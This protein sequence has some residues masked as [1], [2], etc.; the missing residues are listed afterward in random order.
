[1]NTLRRFSRR[2]W[3]LHGYLIVSMILGP[4]PPVNSYW[5]DSDQDGVKEWVNDPAVGGAWWDLD[6]DG[7]FLT[8]AEE[9]QFGS[10]PYSKDSD[11]DGLSD[12]VERDYTPPA[13]P[14]DPWKWD[15]DDNGCSD[16]DEYYHLIQGYIPVVNYLNLP[17]GAAWA[18]GTFFSFSD[19]DGDGTTNPNDSDPLNMDNDSDGILNWEDSWPDDAANGG[20]AWTEP[21][22]MTDSD[23][24]G[25]DDSSDP[26]PYGSYWHLGIEYGGTPS[27]RDSDGIP[28]EV[29]SFPDGS[30]WYNGFEY[31]GAGS[32]QD[33]DGI[34]DDFDS[35]PSIAGSYSYGG[36]EYPGTWNDQDGDGIPDPADGTSEG[37]YWYNG[38]EYI[39]A[40]V[41]QDEDGIPD[42]FDPFPATAGSYTYDGVEYPGVWVDSDSDGT[43]DALD[44]TPNGGYLYNGV[45][46]TGTWI[47]TDSD[48]V[49]DPADSMP[50]G[51]Y[52]WNNVEYEGLWYDQ[53]NDGIPDA[54]D[55][56]PAGGYWYGDTEYA[57][58]WIDSDGDTIP[59]PADL[60]PNGS[61]WY[62]G[63]EYAGTWNDADSDNI[64]DAAD[65]W[66]NDSW[67][68]QPHFSY[69]GS[70]YAGEWSDRDEDSVPDAADSWPDDPENGADDD[71]DGLSNY[72]ERTQHFT[73][74]NDVDSDDDYLTDYEELMVFH[75]NPLAPRTN[76][77]SGQTLLDGQL[78]L[79]QLLM[80]GDTDG[81]GLPDVL[82]DFY[83][84]LGYD[85]KKDRLDPLDPS[86]PYQD[87]G[88]GDLD[89]DGISNREAFQR[90][91]S[92]IANLNV[93]DFD[94][95]RID[96]AVEDYWAAVYPGSLDKT[97]FADAV[98]DFDQDGLMNYEEVI[99][100][101]IGDQLV[102]LNPGDS[103]SIVNALG[104]SAAAGP[105]TTDGQIMA[106]WWDVS[107][108][109][110]G[111]FDDEM[112]PPVAIAA[113][114]ELKDGADQ[115]L[116]NGMPD[117]YE[118]WL[119]EVGSNPPRAVAAD[120]DGDGI[121]NLWEY[122]YQFDLRDASDAG[123]AQGLALVSVPPAGRQP[124]PSDPEF[125]FESGS[126]P[127]FNTEAYEAAMAAYYAQQGLHLDALQ[128]LARI[129]PD[130]DQLSNR[131]EFILG[132]HPR[133][134][135][136]D[137]DG[138]SDLIETQYGTD[139]LVT[140]SV[141]PLVLSVVSGGDGT[142]VV[143]GQPSPDPLVVRITQGGLAT[144]GVPVT[145]SSSTGSLGF[146]FTNSV[147]LTSGPDG[148]S[149][150]PIAAANAA[151]GVSNLEVSAVGVVGTTSV[152]FQILAAPGGGV[153]GGGGPVGGGPVSTEPPPPEYHVFSAVR[154]KSVS[155]RG[156]ETPTW[157]RTPEVTSST[158]S[159]F[160]HGEPG[161]IPP[162]GDDGFNGDAD[163]EN[164]TTDPGDP[165]D[166]AKAGPLPPEPPLI[167]AAEGDEGAFPITETVHVSGGEPSGPH[168]GKASKTGS[169]TAKNAY[170]P[171]DKED[172]PGT[173]F[174]EGTATTTMDSVPFHQGSSD[175]GWMGNGPLGLAPYQAHS[176]WTQGTGTHYLPYTDSNGDAKVSELE[177]DFEQ[178]FMSHMEVRLQTNK[179]VDPA[180][181]PPLNAIY[182]ILKETSNVADFS[183]TPP[184]VEP[185]ATV[186]FSISTGKL[187]D[188]VNV[189]SGTLPAGI[190]TTSGTLS[191][192]S[193]APQ[194]GKI[195]RYSVKPVG[196]LRD[197]DTLNDNWEPLSGQLARALPGELI[198]L[199][200]N[201]GDLPTDVTLGGFSW[202]LPEKTFGDYEANNSTGT[203][204]PVADVGLEV[205][206][207]Y[208]AGSGRQS[209]QL[210][211]T[212]NGVGVTSTVLINVVKPQS[213][214][215]F[216]RAGIASLFYGNFFKAM[217]LVPQNLLSHQGMEF[218]GSIPTPVGWPAGRMAW[219]QLVTPSRVWTYANGLF[220]GHAKNNIQCLD[221]SYP[222]AYAGE[223]PESETGQIHPFRDSPG[224]PLVPGRLTSTVFDQFTLYL[225]FKPDGEESK[226]VPVKRQ[227][228]SWSG[229]A[230]FNEAIQD[231]IVPPIPPF[232]GNQQETS[233]HPQ[234]QENVDTN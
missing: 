109:D 218:E 188:T 97:I 41:D 67:N 173:S 199:K 111:G 51:S 145:F 59:D 138:F 38:T 3:L 220:G 108:P 105:T 125:Y 64:P 117:G 4:V 127:S 147:T 152:P 183:G 21:A 32:D 47:D 98:E 24:D 6:S 40:W 176:S 26:F 112:E 185:V 191:V 37:S 30:Y 121:P 14:F 83:V 170:I 153:P 110:Y 15:S 86:S 201:R 11:R 80:G 156:E 212:I 198:N 184:I 63:M 81:D 174:T 75:T 107:R 23:G 227:D 36:I 82:E 155:Y 169:Y 35:W 215:T 57:G 143:A 166:E 61:Y 211:Y 136:T 159:W 187:S 175:S 114:A 18:A 74:P 7:D 68:G 157:P 134:A 71:N 228:W 69:N 92:L 120:E 231:W 103:R 163:L 190:T 193:P 171:P 230:T 113:S 203:L 161:E 89:G 19:A 126:G 1:M 232:I 131:R 2:A 55:A 58:T 189:L 196:F 165:R 223:S 149:V 10:D 53:D 66:P 204:I 219:V 224:T 208:F 13:L 194:V 139:P 195:V 119:L 79:G 133:V 99:R 151:P 44:A 72:A 206:S 148:V 178:A 202:T 88:S 93:S 43:P 129:D 158:T 200:I 192:R 104:L 25:I 122:R 177:Y 217:K 150:N 146:G 102:A 65:G 96:D 140:G 197:V 118:R 205:C 142:S 116:V 77:A 124:L 100:H 226:Y 27:D 209:V 70:E 76:L 46:Y 45:E 132:T 8:N 78:H 62:N 222:F 5:T 214:I 95:D 180:T 160:V 164:L 210:D 186:K 16:F 234:W 162:L 181:M 128:E 9:L 216:K 52:W 137:N 28:D 60:T 115:N 141:P 39:G 33:G 50:N 135:D 34:P 29:D 167:P 56:T 73:D 22:T 213:E 91:W 42:P 123:P 54:F 20:G 207:F 172:E 12:L 106:W 48:G 90:G 154:F 84:A 94:G 233:T 31:A 168:T 101:Q 144:S 85:L 17:S 87:D 179:D 229:Q 221:T 49:P 130:G 225:M 182:I